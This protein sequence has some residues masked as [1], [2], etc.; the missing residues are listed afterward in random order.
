MPCG[1]VPHCIEFYPKAEENIVTERERKQYVS[2][3][4]GQ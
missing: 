3:F 4:N 2:E 1:L